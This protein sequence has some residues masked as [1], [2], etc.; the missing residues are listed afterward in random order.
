[1]LKG[2]NPKS[3]V[4]INYIMP[5][6]KHKGLSLKTLL[7]IDPGY[8]VWLKDKDVLNIPVEIYNQAVDEDWEDD[9]YGFDNGWSTWMDEPF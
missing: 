5:F 2:R 9:D 6:G 8:V 7:D 1:M 3:P 4:T